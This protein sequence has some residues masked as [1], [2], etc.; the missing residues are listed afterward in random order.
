MF[1]S[2]Y[3]HT[4]I[5]EYINSLIHLKP[6]SKAMYRYALIAMIPSLRDDF[7]KPSVLAYLNSAMFKRMKVSSQ[8]I[9][10]IVLRMFLE[11][12]SAE[13]EY[14]KLGRELK[15]RINRES[16]PTKADIN[17]ILKKLTSEVDRSMFIL[18]CESGCRISEIINI[19]LQHV[20]NKT[21]HYIIFIPES[22]TEQRNIPL[23]YSAPYLTAWLNVHPDYRPDQYLFVHLYRGIYRRY[24]VEG[25]RK[26][27]KK[28]GTFIGKEIH[29][30]LLRHT[31]VT[32]DL[33]RGLP[34]KQT[35]I[36]H[37]FSIK[38]LERYEHLV[39]EDLE[40]S[41]LALHGIE[42]GAEEDIINLVENTECPRCMIKNPGSNRFCSR[43]GSVLDGRQLHAVED[44][45]E[46]LMELYGQDRNA[47]IEDILDHLEARLKNTRKSPGP[48]TG[49]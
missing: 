29:P 11:Y 28:C 5:D 25:V 27:I 12:H 31:S 45:K 18:F 35:C 15:K 6:K 16:L 8:N 48:N 1:F 44:Q 13:F 41:E 19:K 10:K 30:H 39:S 23:V 42:T 9:Y 43:C 38:M 20:Y 4:K 22:K 37:G 3:M 24:S 17:L 7:R 32:N 26:K 47:L 14:I 2:I 36:K 33:R 34:P 40:K 46:E 21:T 49:A